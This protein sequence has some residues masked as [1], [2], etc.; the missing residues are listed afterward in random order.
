M[1]NE[2]RGMNWNHVVY[3]SLHTYILAGVISIYLRYFKVTFE[4]LVNQ[5]RI[6]ITDLYALTMNE[7]LSKINMLH[8]RNVFFMINP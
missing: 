1:I 7:I 4:M 6:L 5:W 3:P 2:K 8:N